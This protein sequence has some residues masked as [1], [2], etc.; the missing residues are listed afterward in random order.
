MRRQTSTFAF[1]CRKR[2]DSILYSLTQ[3]E[4]E[5]IRDATSA[6]YQQC[7]RTLSTVTFCDSPIG[8]E[9][10]ARVERQKADAQKLRSEALQCLVDFE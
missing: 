9:A 4:L 3:R 6:L 1:V 8:D 10:R 7:E 2:G 5:V